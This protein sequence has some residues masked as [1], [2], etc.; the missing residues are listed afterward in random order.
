M[1][2]AMAVTLLA[3]AQ[4]ELSPPVAAGGS[5]GS[6]PRGH[7]ELAW[8]NWAPETFE[9]AQAEDR[10]LLINVV[11]SWCHWCHVMEERTYAD[12]EV[13]AL[14]AKHFVTI[15]VDSDARPD[16]AERY[17][18]WGW[19]ATAV[20]SSTAQPVLEL[21]GYQ[22][23]ERFKAMLVGLVADRDAGRLQHRQPKPVREGAVPNGDLDK[24][25]QR[26]TAQLDAYYDD[27]QEGWGRSQK[28]PFA[29]PV[30]HA[31]MRATLG[32]QPR[33]RAR[34]LATLRNEEKLVDP[35]W[36]GI[37]QY[38]VA[39]DWEH[40][41]YEK[42][43]VLQAGAL[44]NF[45]QAYRVTGDRRWLQTAQ[46]IATYM[47]D[48]MRAPDGGFYTSQDADLR[49][50]TGP[51]TLGKDYYALAADQRRKLGTPRVDTAVYADL[52]GPMIVGFAELYA[53]TGDAR[54][55]S[56]AVAT[57]ARL[58]V[59]HLDDTGAFGHG[60]RGEP[61][62]YLRDQVEMGRALVELYRVTA[63]RAYLDQAVRT[64]DYV[65]ANLQDDAGGF[66]AHS[67]DP[68]AV[69]V[70]AQRRK[71]VEENGTTARFLV[72]LHRYRREQPRYREAAQRALQALGDQQTVRGE[73]RIIGSYLLGLEALS[74][75]TLD[76]TV[77]GGLD[78]AAT[79]RLFAAALAYY[80][81]RATVELSMPGTRYPDIGRPAVYL[82]TQSA[83]STPVTDPEQFDRKA[84]A[85]VQASL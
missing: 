38:S 67:K 78:D 64:A 3:C 68:A 85:F 30:E 33:W 73:G 31:F 59:T 14:L 34:A 15:K 6:D 81:P 44:Q 74:L 26:T 5:Q 16:L 32:K 21:R 83:C 48:F 37:Y 75:P 8:D 60:A 50:T 54:A 25:R 11:A 29:E 55:L 80:E 45:A 84:A 76:V 43:T 12:P 46:R 42:I 65:L 72:A 23:P 2:V 35:V 1:A 51:A 36:G 49:P 17:R 28:Y 82:C 79:R 27:E 77:V 7:V 4:T 53:A 69:G 41:H 22:P 56:V 39:G 57:M 52:N 58:Q 9:R 71:P 40:P 61:M 20:L 62:V 63:D 10:L 13:A 66:F 18:E 47:N 24:I 19:P 70:F